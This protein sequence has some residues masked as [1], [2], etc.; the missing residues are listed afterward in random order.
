[1]EM[2]TKRKMMDKHGRRKSKRKRQREREMQ[3]SSA[4]K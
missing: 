4:V 2:V 3:S 1:M